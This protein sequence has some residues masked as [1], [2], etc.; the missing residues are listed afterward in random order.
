MATARLTAAATTAR[1]APSPAWTITLAV[2]SRPRRGA[3][4]RVAVIVWWRNSPATPRMPSSR[5][6]PATIAYGR[7]DE[8]GEAAA[9]ERRVAV[10][11]GGGDDGDRG[12]RAGGGGGGE[13]DRREADAALLAQ[14]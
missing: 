8:L 1:R 14:L 3:A 10:V 9:V 5:A 13:G 11:A 7:V 12:Q 2:R 6:A 4:S